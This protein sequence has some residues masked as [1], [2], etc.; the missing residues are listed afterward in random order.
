MTL[1]NWQAGTGSNQTLLCSASFLLHFTLFLHSV[2]LIS[3]KTCAQ[4]AR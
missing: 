3:V 2:L 1:V 4:R